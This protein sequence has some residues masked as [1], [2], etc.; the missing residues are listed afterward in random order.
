MLTESSNSLRQKGGWEYRFAEGYSFL[1]LCQEPVRRSMHSVSVGDT[2]RD[3]APSIVPATSAPTPSSSSSA[4]TSVSSLGKPS[5]VNIIAHEPVSTGRGEEDGG[6]RG[7]RIANHGSRQARQAPDARPQPALP[8]PTERAAIEWYPAQDADALGSE[9]AVDQQ[10][11]ERY[12]RG[13]RQRK[14]FNAV[15]SSE[16][17]MRFNPTKKVKVWL[18]GVDV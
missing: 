14:K 8:R 17:Q 2:S 12:Y 4:T 1:G 13:S 3:T 18:D 7:R 15:V 6:I 11:P 10:Q 9:K 5:S 16:K